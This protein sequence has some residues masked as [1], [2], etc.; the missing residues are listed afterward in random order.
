MRRMFPS[1]H[2]RRRFT[3]IELLVVIAIIA[4][5]A[6]M[7]LP[8]L[9]KARG[10][11][12]SIACLNNFG[13]MS[14]AWLQYVS[15]NKGV[16]P[17][18]YNAASWAGASRVW[19]LAANMPGMTPASRCG[20]FSSYLGMSAPDAITSGYALGSFYRTNKGQLYVNSLFCPARAD[21]MRKLIASK[22]GNVNV[23]YQGGIIS[24]CWA[25]A[26]KLST[27][28]R[29]SRSMAGCEGPFGSAYVS[30][31]TNGNPPL[32]VFPHDNPEPSDNET[33]IAANQSAFG[34]GK[35]SFF[36]YDGHVVQLARMKVPTT[37]RLTDSGPTAA[38]YS[39][40]WQPFGLSQRHD[41]W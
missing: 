17:S 2:N 23:S 14:K 35:C 34:P 29:P 24:N 21:A 6:S 5:L 20:M 16:A 32:P 26:R 31:R 28:R 37:E 10:R 30:S 41:I 33:G 3:L 13:N 36:F 19:Y 12:Q 9:Q 25:T 4:I 7:L 38:F 39:S 18:L 1:S 27:A 40:F 8:A 22:A 11:A 15:D